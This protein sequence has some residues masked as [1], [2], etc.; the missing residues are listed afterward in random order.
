MLKYNRRVLGAGSFMS[1]S[2]GG[3]YPNYQ[4]LLKFLAIIAMTVDHVGLCF[5]PEDMGYRVIG[6]YAMPVF[7]FFVGYNFKTRPN[8]SLLFWGGLL[9]TASTIFIFDG[10]LMMTNSL[11][12][13]FLGQVYLYFV[14][15]HCS[16]LFK[17]YLH[18]VGLAML[19]PFT[20]DLVDYGTIGLAI[21]I[22]GHMVKMGGMG[23][24]LGAFVVAFTNILHTLFNFPH[25]QNIDM[26][27]SMI[28]GLLIFISIGM[29]HFE[30]KM[31]SLKIGSFDIRVI[32]RN[33]MWIYA[34]QIM[35]VQII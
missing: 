9:Y 11:I 25:F 34:P 14:R 30:R 27:L 5:F 28:V 23:V 35:I 32:S 10:R 12:S 24:R 7:Y 19:W 1:K 29:G 15:K 17:G 26:V 33:S 2:G 6:R 20:A 31:S 13:I 18:F 8:F 4:D 21:I 3:E 16:N 22:I